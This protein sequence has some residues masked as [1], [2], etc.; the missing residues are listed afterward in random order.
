MNFKAWLQAALSV[1][2][3]AA[4][5]QAQSSQT[6]LKYV[7]ESPEWKPSGSPRQY[8]EN[9]IATVAGKAAPTIQRY[10]LSGLTVQE[11]TSSLGRIRLSLYE[12]LDT[13]AAYGFF[14]FQ[15]N[16]QQSGFTSVP[17]GTEGFRTGTT[18]YFWQSKYVVKMEGDSGAADSFG[19]LVAQNIFGRSHKPTVSEHLPPNNLVQDSEKY[20]VDAAGLDSSLGF[21]ASKL[22]F[23]D[24]LEIATARYRVN[25]QTVTLALLLYPTQ[26]VAKKFE[27][28]WDS[29]SPD[30]KAFRK[31]VGPLVAWV[32]E[33]K[34]AQIAEQVLQSVGYESAVTWNQNHPDVSLRTVV[35]TIFTFIGI[36]LLFTFV[37]GLSFGGLRIFVKARYP[38]RVFDRASD[39]EIIQLRLDQSLTRKELPR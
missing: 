12:M 10:G 36:A 35:L 2:V 17:L 38:D 20:I 34:D 4:G 33:T 24:D 8:D 27:E 13:S 28:S 25:N 30:D 9:S 31:R 7:S 18:T 11:W 37:A 15:R 22:G 3:L 39:M 19:R 23:E 14:T 32:R 1:L 6:L 16:P 5:L 26:H 29:A 21:D